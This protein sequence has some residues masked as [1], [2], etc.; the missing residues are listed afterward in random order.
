MKSKI[1]FALFLTAIVAG[2]LFAATLPSY[3]DRGTEKLTCVATNGATV[4]LNAKEIVLN[5]YGSA[6]GATN[7]VTISGTY[8]INDFILIRV[9]AGCTNKVLIADNGATLAL[10]ADVVLAATDTLVVKP[11]SATN[12]VKISSSSN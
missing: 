7:T 9:A 2:T 5:A 10:G 6:N 12:A 1:A 8:Y 3:E 4:G 11:V